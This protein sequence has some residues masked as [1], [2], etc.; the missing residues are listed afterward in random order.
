VVAFLPGVT[1]SAGTHWR[2]EASLVLGEHRG[3]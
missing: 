1:Q 2:L 3:P